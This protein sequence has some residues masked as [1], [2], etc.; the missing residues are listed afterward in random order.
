MK[1]MV[2][3]ALAL[4]LS[5]SVATVLADGD[6]VLRSGI[7]FGDTLETVHAKETTLTIEDGSVGK[8]N[9]V[10]FA[11][12]I[13]GYNG[14]ARF[15]FDQT[16][17][18]LTDMLYSFESFS[19]MDQSNSQYE[20][21]RA[22]LIRKYGQPLN[23]PEGTYHAVKGLSFEHSQILI[24]LW[25][26]LGEGQGKGDVNYY[27]EWIVECDGYNVKIDLVNYYYGV[28]GT[29]YYSVDLSYRCFMEDVNEGPSVV[30]ADDIVDK[31]L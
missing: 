25:K 2:C 15:D 12:V 6:F 18:G 10:W 17:G 22:G 9:K 21:L 24:D 11:G 13:S 4:V 1:K 14:S 3:F 23:N 19:T 27:D 30:N 16:T 31:D 5:L 8:T 20:V 29:Y 26:Q 7:L 28:R